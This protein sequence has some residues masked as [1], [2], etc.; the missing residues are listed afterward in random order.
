MNS[1]KSNLFSVKV[2]DLGLDESP[3]L[4]DSQKK[5]VRIWMRNK[6]MDIV[7]ELKPAHTEIFDVFVD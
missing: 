6:I 4:S 5:S 2:E 7:D 3:F 1:H